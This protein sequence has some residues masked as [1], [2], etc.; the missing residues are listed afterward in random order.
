MP[1][2]PIPNV[3]V[4]ILIM[5]HKGPFKRTLFSEHHMQHEEQAEDVFIPVEPVLVS[6]EKAVHAC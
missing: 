4:F 3:F 5:H 1:E 2:R 6:R